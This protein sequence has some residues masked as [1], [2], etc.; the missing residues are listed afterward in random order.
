MAAA[1]G[2]ADNSQ[3]GVHGTDFSYRIQSIHLRHKDIDHDQIRSGLFDVIQAFPAVSGL[4]HLMTAGFQ[5]PVIPFDEVSDN[6]GAT[7]P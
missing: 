7:E 1:A 4:Q 2:H 6:A 3:A 5:V